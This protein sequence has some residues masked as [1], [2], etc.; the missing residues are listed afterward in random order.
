MVGEVQDRMSIFAN[1]DDAGQVLAVIVIPDEHASHGQKYIERIIGLAG[2][3]IP[4]GPADQY[5]GLG[6]SY[7]SGE[8]IA[9]PPPEFNTALL[10]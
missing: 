7:E 9:P 2:T 6:W 1:V 4:A 5:P 3:W 10:P 8:F